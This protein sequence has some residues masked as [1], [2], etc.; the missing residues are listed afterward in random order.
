MKFGQT[1]F[2]VFVSKIVGAVL[3]FLATIYF[4]RTLGASIYGY[5]VLAIAIV[6]WLK[7]AGSF[8]VASAMVKRMSE[9]EE[10]DAYLTASVGLIAALGAILAGLV[11]VFREYVNSY[12]GEAVAPLVAA[13][14]LVGLFESIGYAGLRGERKVHVAGMLGPVGKGLRSLFQIGLVFTGFGLIGLLAGHLVG[15]LLAGIVA[16]SL[17]SVGF[18]RP[19]RRHVR[20]LYDYAKYSWL[21]TL[22]GRSFNDVDVLLLGVFFQSSVVGVYA[23][24]WSIAKFLTLFDS[25]ITTTLFPEISRASADEETRSVSLLVEQSL[26][27]GGL[28]LIPGLFG[29]ALLADRLLRIYGPEFTQGTTVLWV[30]VLAT[31]V[32]AYQKQLMTAIS[33][34]DRPDISFRINAVFIATNVVLNVVLIATIGFVGAAIATAA[35]AGLGAVLAGYKMRQIVEF[36]MPVG[37]IGRQFLAAGV[38]AVIVWGLES[39]VVTS[40]GVSNNVVI[41]GFLVGVGGATYF[42]TLFSISAEFRATVISNS[43]VPLP[44]LSG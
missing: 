2:I 13:I 27:F 10:P 29:A 12:V 35:S 28:F 5:Y 22:K 21:G 36:Q 39:L 37:E 19:T 16:V 30:L 1:S 20:S 43:P 33:G 15:S 34:I 23:V 9:G 4:T 42:L 38:M 14:L 25:A 32:Y 11:V 8:G 31:L 3:G 41:L 6:A 24:A 17:V 7:L 18:A 26:A 40:F 44:Y